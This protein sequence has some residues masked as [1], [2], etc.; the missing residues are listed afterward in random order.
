[1]RWT[2][3]SPPCKPCLLLGPK[4]RLARVRRAALPTLPGST[5]RRRCSCW[6]AAECLPRNSI[7]PSTR[8][9]SSKVLVQNFSLLLPQHGSLD[10]PLPRVACARRPKEMVCL[11]L[12]PFL[13]T[14]GPKAAAGALVQVADHVTALCVR[15]ERSTDRSLVPV[16][17]VARPRRSPR[18][19]RPART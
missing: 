13:A 16:R 6:L 11:A 8:C 3:R 7:Y 1:M 10:I 9:V 5:G 2:R 18:A 14:A 19:R 15:R 17:C 4:Q 12:G